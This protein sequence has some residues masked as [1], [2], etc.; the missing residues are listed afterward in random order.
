MPK[1]IEMIK[2]SINE[3]FKFRPK[4]WYATPFTIGITIGNFL[5]IGFL[6]QKYALSPQLNKIVKMPIIAKLPQLIFTYLFYTHSSAILSFL[7]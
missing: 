4:R 7:S 5:N 3:L 2:S 6:F 1:P